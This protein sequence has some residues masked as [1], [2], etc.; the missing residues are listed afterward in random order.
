MYNKFMMKL[1]NIL[2]LVGANGSG[3]STGSGGGVNLAGGL[4]NALAVIGDFLLGIA[5][6]VWG[7]LMTLIF[8]VLKLVLNIMDVLQFFI[9]KLVGI[10][11]YNNPDWS[12]VITLATYNFLYYFN[13]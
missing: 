9:H 5:T 8:N 10:D 1:L 13:R 6:T 3:P 12:D 11:I 2:P 7:W 4:S